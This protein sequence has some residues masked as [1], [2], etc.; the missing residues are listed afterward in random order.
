VN[1]VI[2]ITEN[3]GFEFL[4][5]DSLRALTSMGTTTTRRASHVEP[6]PN[7]TDW[8]ADLSPVDGPTLGP[9]DTRDAALAAERLWIETYVLC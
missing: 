3:G 6:A 8:L 9:F 4:Y 2:N 7:G 5:S 1:H